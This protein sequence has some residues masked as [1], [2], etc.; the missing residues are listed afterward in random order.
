M[1][2]LHV[3]PAGAQI[4]AG[5]KLYPLDISQF[6][7]ISAYL[8]V[9]DEQGHFV[10]GLQ[11]SDTRVLENNIS[12]PM[13]SL[14]ELSPGTQFVTAIAPGASLAVRDGLGNTRYDYVAAHLAGWAQNLPS[15]PDDDLS[16]LIDGG[17][18][19][20]HTRNVNEWITGLQSYQAESREDANLQ[21]LSAALDI[22]EDPTDLE[23]MSRVILFITSPLVEG[24]EIGLEN[25]ISRADQQGVRIFVLFVAAPEFFDSP[26]AALMQNLA[27]QTG[28]EYFAFAR[29][30]VLPDP[31]NFLAPLR[32]VY[33]LVYTSQVQTGG[34]YAV[35]IEINTL[36]LQTVSTTRSFDVEVLPPNPIFVSPP[37][38]IQRVEAEI[39]GPG[40]VKQTPTS[41]QDLLM[42]SQ[43]EIGVVIEFP[44]GHERQVITS[45]LYVDNEIADQNIAEPFDQFNWELSSYSDSG[46]HY[47][48]VEVVDQLG[49]V[50]KT[51]DF[52]VQIKVEQKLLDVRAV[53]SGQGLWIVGGIVVVA[54]GILLMVLI[55]GGRIRPQLP[56]QPRT[57]GRNGRAG[58]GPGS[59][60][61]DPLTQP[62]A[63]QDEQSSRWPNW[64]RRREKPSPSTAD[65]FLQ[66]IMDENGTSAAPIPIATGELT[67]G[68]SPAHAEIVL[69]DPSIAD[70]HARLYRT[71]D[72][73]ILKDENS[74]AGTWVNYESISQNG[75]ELTH[76][77][78]VHFGRMHL[79]FTLRKPA[80][81][82]RPAVQLLEETQ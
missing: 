70:L 56:G 25:L 52:P 2:G 42:P 73:Y 10:P 5:A 21:V 24:S 32:S 14:I 8:D 62:V 65:A 40:G 74:V 77:D 59:N 6:P 43:Q 35:N 64:L 7:Y 30:E 55:L 34:S 71:D 47:L 78:V 79:R 44:D 69:D 81:V 13:E 3:L 75:V 80:K 54:G 23:G 37:S 18:Q 41:D 22:A 46:T 61:L 9:R 16:L 26:S 67:I 39:S 31:E 38:E 53:M 51:L 48:R 36:S 19:V 50:G 58:A 27:V 12:L 17:P 1:T 29:D 4:S 57:G 76:G 60:R 15:P 68:S 82:R 11:A 45:T 63:Q 28:G 33:R 49:L 20:I 72:H 66:P